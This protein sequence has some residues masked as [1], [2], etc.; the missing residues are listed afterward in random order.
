MHASAVTGREKHVLLDHPDGGAKVHA[1]Q[2]QQ[3][4]QRG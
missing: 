2:E 1:G 3:V 4:F